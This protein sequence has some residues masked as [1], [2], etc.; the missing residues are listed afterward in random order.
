MDIAREASHIA[1]KIYQSSRGGPFDVPVA[2]LSPETERVAGISSFELPS[3]DQSTSGSVKLVDGTIL[4]GIDRVVACTGY[5]FS[6]P[7][8][9][10]YH[11]DSATPE[12]ANET[13]LVSDGTQMHNL[14][15]DIFYIPDPSL[16]FVG[17]PF[18]TATFTFFEFQAIA[19]AA[20][21]SGR[22]WVPSKEAMQAE[23]AERVKKKGTG[24]LLHNLRG[25]SVEYVDELVEWL[26]TQAEA[27]GGEKIEGYSQEWQEE[28][29]LL[30]DKYAK[31]VQTKSRNLR[32]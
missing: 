27:T 3:D 17:V 25:E 16:A 19:V 28:Q 30:F 4:T 20:V 32:S 31:L 9:L 26:N 22:A 14:H 10:D 8:L 15:K 5:L 24:R 1:K 11:D 7:F 2:M 13:V 21:F 12:N 18:Y 29:K 23:Y 6:L